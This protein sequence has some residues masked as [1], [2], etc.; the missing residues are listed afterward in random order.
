MSSLCALVKQVWGQ[1]LC[2]W[3]REGNAH[4]VRLRGDGSVASWDTYLANLPVAWRPRCHHPL[5]CLQSFGS[6]G[7]EG[8]RTAPFSSSLLVSL[9]R[10]GICAS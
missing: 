1:A 4:L 7:A 10:N 6:F 3:L 2:G 9:L 8:T 5:R